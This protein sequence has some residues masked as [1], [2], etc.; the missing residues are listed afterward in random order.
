MIE[1]PPPF[2]H[3]EFGHSA[4]LCLRLSG[5]V[6]FVSRPQQLANNSSLAVRRFSTEVYTSTKEV[7]HWSKLLDVWGAQNVTINKNKP[8]LN[9]CTS[10]TDSDSFSRATAAHET[11]GCS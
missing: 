5:S 7:L 2:L 4:G 3:V 11:E 8:Q 9:V 6:S 10:L 1:I